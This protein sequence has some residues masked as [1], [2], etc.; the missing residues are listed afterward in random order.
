MV[1]FL[2]LFFTLIAFLLLFCTWSTEL[3][4]ISDSR[5]PYLIL[6]PEEEGF[7]ILPLSTFV[8]FLNVH[9]I[10]YR[11]FYLLSKFTSLFA[12][13]Y[14]LIR[15]GVEWYQ[16]PFLYLLKWVL[17]FPLLFVLCVE[18]HWSFGYYKSNLHLWINPNWMM[19]YSFDTVSYCHSQLDWC[20][21]HVTDLI[22]G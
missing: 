20:F 2:F 8:L 7:S 3:N 13:L 22:S 18:L 5:H 14:I 12:N 6:D 21:L 17:D 9:F 15:M 1:V 19:F 4:R 10:R 16:M 11:R